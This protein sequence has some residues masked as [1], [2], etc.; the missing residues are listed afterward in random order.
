MRVDIPI[1]SQFEIVEGC[2]ELWMIFAGR[3]TGSDKLLR[4]KILNAMQLMGSQ[5]EPLH[6]IATLI[7]GKT[8]PYSIQGA[9]QGSLPS[10]LIKR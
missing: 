8:P 9:M 7:H 6:H 3:E 4:G 5:V 2:E 10:E 1:S